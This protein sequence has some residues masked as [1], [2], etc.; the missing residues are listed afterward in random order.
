MR[1][2]VKSALCL[3]CLGLAFGVQAAPFPDK[4]VNLMVGFTPGTSVDIIA[5]LLGQKLG[6]LWGQ[7]VVVE[8]RAGAGGNIAAGY[9]ARSAPDG[10]TILLVNNSMAIS[11][12]LYRRLNYNPRDLKAV[13]LVSSMPFAL[14]VAPT[15]KATSLQ[16]FIAQAKA[17][18]GQLDFGSGGVGNTDHMTGELFAET[19]G[20]KMVHVPYK[21]GTEAMTDVMSGRISMYFAGV[22]ACLPLVKAGKLKAIATTGAQRSP[23]LP[24]VPTFA[25]SGMPDFQATLWNGLAVPAGTPP[26]VIEKIAADTDKVLRMPDVRQRMAQLGL[27]IEG[28]PPSRFQTLLDAETARW[29]EVVKKTGI[30]LQ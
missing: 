16:Q 14:V 6:E 12:S 13:T 7:S 23:A 10:Y 29:A 30:Q 20:L 5:R 18:P 17:A 4:P 19:A 24:N 9:V 2:L 27:S 3:L 28:G 15:S 11:P 25:E 21:G 1:S 26:D 22:A 8:N